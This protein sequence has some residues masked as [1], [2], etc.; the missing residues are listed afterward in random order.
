MK[1]A[2][3]QTIMLSIAFALAT[4]VLGWGV[5]PALAAIW[6]F[7]A[8]EEEHPAMVA[9]AG[10]GLGWLLLLVWVATQGP[11]GEVAR[12]AGG[13]M[14][15]PGAVMVILTLLYPMV[16]AWAAAALTNA[17]AESRRA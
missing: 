12:R 4:A 2:A 5:I 17:I 13:V 11:M 6:G 15:V 16:V 9:A 1:R 7:T 3:L 8:R 10:A 14:S